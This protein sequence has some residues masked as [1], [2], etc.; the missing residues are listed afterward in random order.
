MR[1]Q[2]LIALRLNRAAFSKVLELLPASFDALDIT[3]DAGGRDGAFTLRDYGDRGCVVLLGNLELAKRTARALAPKLNEA[4]Q[5]Y[6][7]AGTQTETRFRFSAEAF[8]ATPDGQ[9]REISGV[10][11]DFDDVEQQWGG[12]TL[13]ARIQRVV[14]E[15]GALPSLYTAEKRFGYKRRAA[16]KPSTPRVSTLLALLK[17]ARTWEGVPQD[18]GRVELR[19]VL[20][21]GGK[22][23][24]FCSQAE[25]EELQKLTGGAR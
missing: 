9:L 20:A 1:K 23:S 12:G 7:V 3:I 16:G 22:Q 6:D 17:K 13:E 10:E 18:G 15:Y 11:L 24:S 8:E 25:F 19:V 4:V 14:R 2:E 5:I 21:A